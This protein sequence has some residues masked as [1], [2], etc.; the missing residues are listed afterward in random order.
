MNIKILTLKKSFA[1]SRIKSRSSHYLVLTVIE[2][3]KMIRMSGISLYETML[4][5]GYHKY[6]TM[7][8]SVPLSGPTTA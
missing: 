5:T 3:R 6:F 1:L 4:S 2:I 8:L 7:V